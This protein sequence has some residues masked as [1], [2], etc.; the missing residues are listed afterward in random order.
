MQPVLT[1]GDSSRGL[2]AL[3]PVDSVEFGQLSNMQA[4]QESKESAEHS[5]EPV[6][7]SGTM[8]RATGGPKRKPEDALMQSDKGP[9]LEQIED[10]KVNHNT[11]KNRHD[12][13]NRQWE[14]R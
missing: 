10:P 6:D 9:C 14:C 1:V 5:K 4:T 8:G 3:R 13:N 7:Q 11:G 12:R 2:S